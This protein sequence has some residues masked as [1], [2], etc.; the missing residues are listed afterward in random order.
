MPFTPARAL[1]GLLTAAM[2]TA[3]ALVAGAAGS[4]A[5]TG[6]NLV[7]GSTYLVAPANLIDGHYYESYPRYADFGLTIDAAFA[8]AATGDE[9]PALKGIVEFLDSAGQDPHGNTVNTWTGIGTRYASGGSIGDEVLLA[10]MTGYNPRDFGGHDLIA[11]LGASVCARASAGSNTKCAGAGNY[12]YATSVFDQALGIVAQLRAGQ[13]SEAA[14]P[15]RYLES[16]RNA[17]G[18]F[19]SLIPSTHDQDVDSTAMAVQV[20][21]VLPCGS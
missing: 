18:S 6:P 13:A 9:D 2:M 14:A 4:L 12:A 15:I 20:L 7:T 21:T 5:L 19:P 11:A 16:L 3:G 17:D 1:A 8:L 10:E